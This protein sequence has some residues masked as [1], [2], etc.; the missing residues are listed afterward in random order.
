MLKRFLLL[1]LLLISLGVGASFA[2]DSQ[3]TVSV[4]GKIFRSDTKEPIA[5]ALVLLLNEKK[6]DKHD[7]SVEART[8]EQGNYLF[9]KVVP[10]KYTVSIRAWYTRQEDAPC[11]LLMA[12]TAEKNSTVAVVRDKNQFVQQVFIGGFAVKSGKELVKDFDFACKS[13][14]GG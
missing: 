14:F 12:K 5:N 1:A 2:D 9:E 11:K 4:K 8:D 7:N 6:S 10:G 3:K 13:M